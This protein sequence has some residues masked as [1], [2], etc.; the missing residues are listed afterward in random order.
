METAFAFKKPLSRVTG[1]ATARASQ[2]YI[3]QSWALW[4][5]KLME[6]GQLLNVPINVKSG[7]SRPFCSG[8]PRNQLSKSEGCV[9]RQLP[10]TSH[11][12]TSYYASNQCSPFLQTVNKPQRHQLLEYYEHEK[13]IFFSSASSTPYSVWFT[14][15]WLSA[16]ASQPSLHGPIH[17]PS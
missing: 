15:T 13:A 8:C 4:T 2:P 14:R 17:W 16:W 9:V 7:G 1:G 5:A 11:Y 10:P 3:M 6:P 12:S